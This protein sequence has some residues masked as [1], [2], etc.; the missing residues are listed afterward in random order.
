MARSTVSMLVDPK[1]AE[2][3]IISRVE[4]D[5]NG[6]YIWRGAQ[7]YSGYG[8][9]SVERIHFLVHRLMFELR[10]GPIPDRESPGLRGFM[11]LHKCD[12]PACCNPD[13]LYLGTAADNARDMAARCRMRTGYR[14][15]SYMRYLDDPGLGDRPVG[16]VFWEFRGEVRPLNEWAQLFDLNPI[17]LDQRFRAGWPE[18]SIPQQPRK[19]FRHHAYERI[20]YRRFSGEAAVIAYLATKGSAPTAATVEA[21]EQQVNP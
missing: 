15:N 17:T 9:V 13:H 2:E 7:D 12:V 5:A 11:V 10:S 14:P 6:C 19:G 16:T 21:L 4:V 18:A 1:A 3:R 8:I 20:E